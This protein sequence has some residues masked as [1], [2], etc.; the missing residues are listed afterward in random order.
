[1]RKLS[2]NIVA[3]F[4]ILFV[5]TVPQYIDAAEI[6]AVYGLSV[7]AEE[8][9][10]D[11]SLVY[12]GKSS[13]PPDTLIIVELM[14]QAGQSIA[15]DMAYVKDGGFGGILVPVTYGEIP[16]GKYILEAGYFP[17]RQVDS[18][19]IR[20][21]GK[22]GQKI[23]AASEGS[24]VVDEAS[25]NKKLIAR[26]IMIIGDKETIEKE[27]ASA[28][29]DFYWYIKKL[30]LLFDDLESTYATLAGR[31]YD[32]KEWLKFSKNWYPQL[33][34]IQERIMQ[35]YSDSTNPAHL[36]LAMHLETAAR[37][38]MQLHNVYYAELSDTELK[39]AFERATTKDPAA[40]KKAIRQ[41]LDSMDKMLKELNA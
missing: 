35:G 6:K 32:E 16:N 12:K 4:I 20:L 34:R 3:I 5:F 10:T 15:V 25:G 17:D 37:L 28:K 9:L 24:L 31:V 41:T 33:A 2:L 36:S 8:E 13:L 21:L 38:L 14:A 27:T 39:P 7:E 26:K 1:M 11:G 22:K 23:D 29:N 18:N 19:V 30:N 40:L